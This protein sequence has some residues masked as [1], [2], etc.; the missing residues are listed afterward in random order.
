M[1]GGFAQAQTTIVLPPGSYQIRAYNDN[2]RDG[3]LQLWD[4]KVFAVR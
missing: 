3:T 1:M 2:G 4:T